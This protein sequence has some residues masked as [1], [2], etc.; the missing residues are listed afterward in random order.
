MKLKYLFLTLIFL[1]IGI[2]TVDAKSI[3]Y[4]LT[5]DKNLYEQWLS[6]TLALRLV[7]LQED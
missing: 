7:N 3:E 6:Y 1:I 2:S 5:I 4:N